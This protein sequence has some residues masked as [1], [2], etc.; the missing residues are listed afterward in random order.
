M[1]EVVG[2]PD[3]GDDNDLASTHPS[4]LGD[5]HRQIDTISANNDVSFTHAAVVAV[6]PGVSVVMAHASILRF[7][8]EV[9]CV[10]TSTAG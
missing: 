3:V 6:W 9:S 10:H 4:R 2:A 7:P 5:E 1:V 8:V